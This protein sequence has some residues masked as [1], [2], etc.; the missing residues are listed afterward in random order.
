MSATIKKDVSWENAIY[1]NTENLNVGQRLGVSYLRSQK[2][3][4]SLC[5]D[6][7][8]LQLYQSSTGNLAI[9]GVVWDAGLY[10]SDYMVANRAAAVGRILDIGCGTGI[11]GITALF[12]GATRVSF[13][14]A[15]MPPSFNDN[16]N[17][18]S[19]SHKAQSTFI[20]YDW[21]SEILCS[22][23]ISPMGAII[24]QDSTNSMAPVE[25]WDTVLCSDLLYDQ[26]AH[27]PLLKVL[28]QICFR[29]AIFSYKRRHDE[30][31]KHFFKR[32][33]QFCSLEVV[34]SNSFEL[35]NIP[36]AETSGLF[37]VIAIRLEDMAITY[38]KNE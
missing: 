2:D 19:E 15:F 11:C 5:V 24:C 1:D 38:Q 26:N 10:L 21:S 36:F 13:T 18:L 8:S 25:R 20:S 28:K 7:Q 37:I 35:S 30:P 29:K 16:F 22:E 23:L 9:S 31:E 6:L 3:S 14:D 32:L 34:E 27:E 17:Q 12:L 33:S 4:I